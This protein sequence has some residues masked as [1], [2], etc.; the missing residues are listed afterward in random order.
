M[1]NRRKIN[2]KQRAGMAE[3]T[4]G[5]VTGRGFMPGVSGNPNGRPPSNGLLKLLRESVTNHGANGLTVEELLVQ[6][7]IDE[8]LK[9][10]H[11]LAAI[12]MIFDRLEGKPKQ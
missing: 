7:L 10:K 4:L 6:A 2:A 9:G 3:E 12:S 1:N 11:R 8:A 5:G